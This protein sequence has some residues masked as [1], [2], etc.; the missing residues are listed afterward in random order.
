MLTEKSGRSYKRNGKTWDFPG[1]GAILRSIVCGYRGMDET[2][3]S[4]QYRVAD[5]R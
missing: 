3:V 4:A 2:E 1:S 5:S